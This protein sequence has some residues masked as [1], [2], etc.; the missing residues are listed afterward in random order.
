MD[1]IVIVAGGTNTR[2]DGVKHGPK[3]LTSIEGRTI[4]DRI[5]GTISITTNNEFRVFIAAGFFYNEIQEYV[6]SSDWKEGEVEVI[7]ATQWKEGNAA[8]LL[9]VRDLIE[10]DD[11][12][13]QMS[14]HL[15]SQ[16]TYQRCVSR[17]I[18]PVPYV[19]G[20]PA[21]D[22]IPLY[23][24]LNDA[25]KI[26]ADDSLRIKEI[27]KEILEWNMIDMGVFRLT[28]KA[29][30][31][32]EKLPVDRKSLSNYV[33]EWRKNEPF[34]VSPQ[35]GAVWNDID[36]HVDLDWAIKMAIDGQWDST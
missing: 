28:R 14:D 26:L 4:L 24:D 9:A 29:F 3:T 8:T 11:F 21:S 30:E 25:T 34:Y 27:G 32:I 17:D 31:I 12:V 2:L 6:T 18:V 10:N 15:F 19:C 1:E 5:I 13:L 36:T 33:A 20:Q 22:G 16:Q 35:P 23:L 7:K